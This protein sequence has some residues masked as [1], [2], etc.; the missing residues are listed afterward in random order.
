VIQTVP[1]FVGYDPRESVAYHVCCNSI[2]ERSSV[3]VSF[4]PLHLGLFD[5]YTETHKDGSNAF[6]YT[7][8]LVPWLM[9]YKGHAIF[10][11]GDMVVKEDIAKLWAERDHY[12]AVQ[13]VKSDYKTKFPTKYLGNKNEDYPRK[14]WSSV[15][16][17]NCGHFHNRRL[18]PE[19]ISKASGAELHR[20]TW[21]KDSVIGDLP[22]DWNHLC[23]EY[24]ENPSSKLDHYTIGL[25]CFEGFD[26]GS[27]HADNW[28]LEYLKATKPL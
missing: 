9:K 4:H 25:P 7:R 5:D 11:D 8:F 16:L 26:T 17:W 27:W 20:F 28:W 21:L 13:V 14:N 2:I 1:V 22:T 23:E 12:K 10:L 15:I 3:P 24:P 19:F 18:T 6:I